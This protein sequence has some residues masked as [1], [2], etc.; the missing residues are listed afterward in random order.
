VVRTLRV[1][2]GTCR[3]LLSVSSTYWDAKITF[4][5]IRVKAK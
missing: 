3:S 1:L 4:V 5:R 2:D